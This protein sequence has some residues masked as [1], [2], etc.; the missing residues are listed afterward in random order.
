MQQA[1]FVIKRV[2]AHGY[3]LSYT[4]YQYLIRRTIMRK[5]M[6]FLK[7]MYFVGRIWTYIK[8]YQKPYCIPLSRKYIENPLINLGDT[9]CAPVYDGEIHCLHSIPSRC[10]K[11]A[12]KRN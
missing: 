11:R 4:W 9:K 7:S 5:L 6:S 10:T 8:C 3:F 12:L 2:I 1:Q